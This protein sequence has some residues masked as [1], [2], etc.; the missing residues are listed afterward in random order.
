MEIEGD[1]Q[2]YLNTIYLYFLIVFSD[3]YNTMNRALEVFI[4]IDF[5]RTI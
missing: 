4:S 3:G 1:K 5:D 2:G